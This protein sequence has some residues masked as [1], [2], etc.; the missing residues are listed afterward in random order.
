MVDHSLV[1]LDF[2]YR[3]E[4]CELERDQTGNDPTSGDGPTTGRP[5]SLP[6]PILES[7]WGIF[8]T[9]EMESVGSP[10]AYADELSGCHGYSVRWHHSRC[11][12]RLDE[13]LQ[14]ILLML[15]VTWKNICGPTARIRRCRKS[16]LKFQHLCMFMFCLRRRS[17]DQFSTFVSHI[18]TFITFFFFCCAALSFSFCIS[19]TWSVNNLQ[20]N[21]EKHKCDSSLTSHIH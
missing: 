15:L 18:W 3:R 17:Y 16:A 2:L 19:I 1:N 12:Q 20:E 8:L 5:L 13:T 10:V 11:L 6:S 4:I 21:Q 14:K 7:C 9:M